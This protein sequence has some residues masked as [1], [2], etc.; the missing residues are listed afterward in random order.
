MNFFKFLH[1]RKREKCIIELFHYF[2]ALVP[3][4]KREKDPC[5]FIALEF[6]EFGRWQSSWSNC[7]TKGKR[8]KN[9]FNF[10]KV[11]KS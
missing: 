8:G 9:I 1:G 2:I 6:E 3:Q 7:V 5:E 4:L 10:N 11:H